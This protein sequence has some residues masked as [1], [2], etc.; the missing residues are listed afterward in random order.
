MASVA[1]LFFS[2]SLV[3]LAVVE[4]EKLKPLTFLVCFIELFIIVSF[5]GDAGFELFQ[6]GG[7]ELGE[8]T[9]VNFSA[10]GTMMGATAYG[11]ES[12][13]SMLSSKVH[14]FNITSPEDNEE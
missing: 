3:I 9:W 5:I 7:P 14:L 8:I 6:K 10:L 13:G 11:F 2:H 1:I 4:P 12:N